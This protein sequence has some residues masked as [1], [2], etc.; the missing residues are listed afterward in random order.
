MSRFRPIK[1]YGDSLI[2]RITSQD[3]IDLG[4][5]VGDEVDISELTKRD[6]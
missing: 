6:A 4:L 3:L 2:I 1:K 5:V